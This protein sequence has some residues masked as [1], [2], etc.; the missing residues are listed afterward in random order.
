MLSPYNLNAAL[1]FC[2]D[3]EGYITHTQH[4]LL[5]KKLALE[6]SEVIGTDSKD[7]WK[8]R[9]EMTYKTKAEATGANGNQHGGNRNG[10]SGEEMRQ[11][12][13]WEEG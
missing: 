2:A 8:F 1:C 11:T 6:C 3:F 13:S 12:D 5:L 10:E 7:R 9:N 4:F